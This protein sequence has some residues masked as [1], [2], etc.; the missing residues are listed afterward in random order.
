MQ[1]FDTR[2]TPD[3]SPLVVHFTRD[4]RLTVDWRVSDD[5]PLYEQKQA[6]APERLVNILREC[7][8]FASPIPFVE[9]NPNAVCFSECV[10]PAIANLSEQYSP[11]GLVFNKRVLFNRGGGPALYV[12]GDMMQNGATEIPAEIRPLISPFDPD[13]VLKEGR[14]IDWIHE[15][16]WRLPCDLKFVDAEVEYVIVD[17]VADV[18]AL[19]STFGTDRIPRSKFIVMEVYR[20]IQSAWGGT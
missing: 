7:T 14:P 16:E 6:S 2:G 4:R 1:G 5:H 13:A 19:T 9:E 20:N 3:Y 11:Y 17:T 18:Q 8:I 12:R 10:W 15:R